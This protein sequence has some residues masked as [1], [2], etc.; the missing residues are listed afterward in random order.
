MQEEKFETNTKYRLDMGRNGMSLR[1]F[2]FLNC[3][4]PT[5]CDFYSE[6]TQSNKRYNLVGDRMGSHQI[7]Q[8]L[9]DYPS[10]LPGMLQH[11]AK[12]SVLSLRAHWV[13]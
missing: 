2:M 4:R 13:H 1:W 7:V 6:F 10:R 8:F 5:P 11:F 3:L 9:S 12:I